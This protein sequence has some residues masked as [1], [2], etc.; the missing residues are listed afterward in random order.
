MKSEASSADLGAPVQ[1]VTTV[2]FGDY[3]FGK[4]RFALRPLP[5]PA[6]TT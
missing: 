6:I 3:D 1:L 4:Q 2:T 5:M